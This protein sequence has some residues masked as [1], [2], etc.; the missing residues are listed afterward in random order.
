LADHLP[1]GCRG[2]ENER[3]KPIGSPT[4]DHSFDHGSDFVD[5]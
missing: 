1:V 3:A 5:R 2:L 4:A